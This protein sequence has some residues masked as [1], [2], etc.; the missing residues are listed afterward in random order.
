MV[1]TMLKSMQRKKILL[2]ALFL[3][4]SCNDPKYNSSSTSNISNNSYR[5][6]SA[7][8]AYDVAV[9]TDVLAENETHEDVPYIDTNE[10]F[11]NSDGSNICETINIEVKEDFKE[12]NSNANVF[13]GTSI[14]LRIIS[15]DQIGSVLWSLRNND[16]VEGFNPSNMV[17]SPTFL[18]DT[19]REYIFRAEVKLR[20][21]EVTCNVES[22]A[23]FGLALPERPQLKVEVRWEAPNGEPNDV[24]NLT[25]D[26]DLHLT[27]NNAPWNAAP[28]DCFW[29][30]P[31]PN[32]GLEDNSIDDP[33]LDL[34]IAENGSRSEVISI[35]IPRDDIYTIGIY[36]SADRGYGPINVEL[37]IYIDNNL[38]YAATSEVLDVGDF[39]QAANI[40]WQE[41][42][43]E[44]INLY[45]DGFP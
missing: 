11:N 36:S 34:S 15:S 8:S 22:E 26:M 2:T 42:E 1:Y 17:R 45:N 12:W 13:I 23:I 43:I 39:W 6:A 3:C 5:D 35:H 44:T 4:I 16:S 21:K 38:E 30:N 14:K 29:L 19:P 25:S 41:R 24:L 10:E 28:S 31:N 32:W 33:F 40:N 37:Y 18:I 20:D 27:R 7:D 9:S